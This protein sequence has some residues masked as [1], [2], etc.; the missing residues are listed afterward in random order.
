MK[1]EFK[2]LQHELDQL[3]AEKEDEQRESDAHSEAARAENV[4]LWNRAELLSSDV[5]HWK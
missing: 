2:G 1:G 3:Q 4:E 5:S